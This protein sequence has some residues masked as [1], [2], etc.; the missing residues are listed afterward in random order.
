MG[1]GWRRQSATVPW[2]DFE[3]T[4]GS[5][6]H[7]A[8]FSSAA[9]FGGY[10]STTDIHVFRRGVS[11][12]IGVGVPSPEFNDIKG[13]KGSRR[14]RWGSIFDQHSHGGRLRCPR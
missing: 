10:R 3:F 6:L 8:T 1:G 12:M 4:N 11:A 14:R 2:L 9:E 13:L 5:F 7:F